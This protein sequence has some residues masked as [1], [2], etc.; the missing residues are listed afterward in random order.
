MDP[1]YQSISS[2]KHT[3]SVISTEKHEYEED[4]TLNLLKKGLQDEIAESLYINK[5]K[6]KPLL[7]HPTDI[8]K[9]N[10]Q[11]NDP[12]NLKRLNHLSKLHDKGRK[13]KPKPLSSREKKATGIY[14]ISKNACKY[15]IW[16]VLHNLWKEYI[17]EIIGSSSASIISQ[18]LLKADMHGSKLKVI[19]SKCPSRV[20]I[21]GI[22]IKE[23]KKTF[24]LITEKNQQKVIPKENSVFSI[25]IEQTRN[26]TNTK[27]DSYE[28][29]N[30]KHLM[31]FEIMGPHFIYRA[32]ERIGKKIKSKTILEL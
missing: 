18:K 16:I 28:K 10:E 13:K 31:V 6:N 17:K 2:Q 8:Y 21:E 30:E 9:S 29:I 32:A 7:I 26:H 11:G 27:Q 14:N 12:R 5:V 24:V 19:R 23:T 25:E 1:L 15:N 3:F 20:G 22:C 4:I